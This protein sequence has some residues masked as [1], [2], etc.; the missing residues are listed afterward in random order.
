MQDC[1]KIGFKVVAQEMSCCRNEQ[2]K[3]ALV[4]AR[5]YCNGV[6]STLPLS[7]HSLLPGIRA[8]LGRRRFTLFQLR[9]GRRLWY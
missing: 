5:H 3:L 9:R 8:A 4:T 1:S 6:I 2:S 7:A